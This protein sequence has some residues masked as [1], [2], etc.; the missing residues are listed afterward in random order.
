MTRINAVATAYP[1]HAT[2][3]GSAYPP[4]QNWEWDL[5]W[6]GEC[7]VACCLLVGDLA[8]DAVAANHEAGD[9]G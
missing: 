5:H 9:S 2:T 4:P 7:L 6:F 8:S 3:S 1:V